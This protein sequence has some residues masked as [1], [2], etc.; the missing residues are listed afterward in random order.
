MLGWSSHG[1]DWWSKYYFHRLKIRQ[2]VAGLD[3]GN[4]TLFIC[5]FVKLYKNKKINQK[6]FCKEFCMKLWKKIIF[7]T[8]DAWLKK[9]LSHQPSHPVY[10][11][12][13]CWIS[14]HASVSS[15]WQAS[16][17]YNY[18]LVVIWVV[19]NCILIVSHC[20]LNKIE[21][22]IFFIKLIIPLWI[23]FVTT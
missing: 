18:Q 6:I 10:Y 1:L 11:F 22:K 17:T 3:L 20:K 4:S 19:Q 12:E 23:A 2:W 7:G 9:R 5:I 21:D 14:S 16:F 15:S 8:S 13:D